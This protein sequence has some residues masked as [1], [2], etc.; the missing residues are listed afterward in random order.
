MDGKA[1]AVSDGLFQ[2][3]NRAA[4]WTIEGATAQHCIKGAGQTPGSTNDQSAY[5]SEL[6][7]LWGILY[8]L[9]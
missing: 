3:G 6:F 4:T 5:Q 1:V 7:G 8:S 2:L 9:K